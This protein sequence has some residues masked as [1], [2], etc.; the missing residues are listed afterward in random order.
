MVTLRLWRAVSTALW[1][2]AG[3]D[4]YPESFDLLNRGGAG[5]AAGRG[6]TFF[7]RSSRLPAG[8]NMYP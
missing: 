8:L 6:T 4:L 3:K 7:T 2:P 1:N 5:S